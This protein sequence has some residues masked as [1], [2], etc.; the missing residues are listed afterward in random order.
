M[1]RSVSQSVSLLTDIF[2]HLYFA[3][4]CDRQ[5]QR[6]KTGTQLNLTKLNSSAREFK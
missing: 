1:T 3:R 2:M 4:K 5:Q 6:N